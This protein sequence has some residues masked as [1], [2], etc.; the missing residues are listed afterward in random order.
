M[1]IQ[2][3]KNFQFKNLILHHTGPD[4]SSTIP[5]YSLIIN[6]LRVNLIFPGL[7]DCVSPFFGDTL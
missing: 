3:I 6:L 4:I 5:K 2:S 7:I 1:L